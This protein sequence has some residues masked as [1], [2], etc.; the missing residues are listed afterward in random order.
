MSMNS[1]AQTRPPAQP[2]INMSGN[3]LVHVS[4]GNFFFKTKTKKLKNAP[5][6]AM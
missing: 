5:Q 4:G 2:P 1:F 6:G 3:F